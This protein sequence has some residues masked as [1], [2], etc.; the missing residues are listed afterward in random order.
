VTDP[1]D[2]RVNIIGPVDTE[3]AGSTLAWS[4]SQGWS[5][6]PP[7]AVPRFYAGPAAAPLDLIPLPAEVLDWATNGAVGDDPPVGIELDDDP[8][9]LRRLLAFIGPRRRVPLFQGF[10]PGSRPAGP[11]RLPPNA[12]ER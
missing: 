4:P 9:A 11:Q 12:T 2:I 6:T 5:L 3:L 10:A 8:D 1:I 7:A